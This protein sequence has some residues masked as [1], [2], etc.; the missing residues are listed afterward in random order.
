M[1]EPSFYNALKLPV[2]AAPMFLISGPEMV[3]ECCKNGI[4]GTVP[5]LNQRTTEG[6]EEWVIEIKEALSAF[7][8]E[9]GKKAAPFG[10]NL[11]V[12]Q[13]NPRVQADLEICMK[14][15]VPIIITSLGAVSQL[16][17]AVHSYGG[18]V[19]HDVVKK[20]HAEKAAEAGVD[21]LILVSAGAGGH[22]G[23]LN[24]MPFVQEI[25]GFF[26]KTILL[27]GCISNGKDVA[28]AMQMGADLAWIGTR[29]I[30]TIE[31]R[32][33]EGYRDM[34]IE[35]GASDVVHTAA[36][37]GIP[38]NFLRPSL[39]AMGITQE[40]WD[41]KAK[42]DFGKELD[43]AKAEA[44]AWK[45]LWSAGQGVA[46]IHDNIPVAE[47]VERLRSEFIDAL[48]HQAELLKRYQ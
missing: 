40:M 2:V 23:T 5:A 29:F 11:I 25:R 27:A 46:T 20:R 45:T 44:K 16:V 37:S 30:N 6:F 47:L 18:L 1:N 24:P 21:G 43:A 17:D 4:V 38:A 39:E 12:H 22:A 28:S 13:T 42:M 32:A 10:V 9:T 8:K 41:T 35:S 26:K 31:S 33:S 7:E 19:W 14:H 36:V 34:I 48:K 3:I 15:K